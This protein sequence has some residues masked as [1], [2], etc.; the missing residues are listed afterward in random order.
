MVRAQIIKAREQDKDKVVAEII[1]IT[2]ALK[3]TPPQEEKGQKMV[4]VQDKI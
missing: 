3:A 4:A 1:K 2:L